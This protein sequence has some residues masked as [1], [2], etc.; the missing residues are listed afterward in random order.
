MQDD[1]SQGQKLHHE[2]IEV[3]K[4]YELRPKTVTKEEILAYGRA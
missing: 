1:L 4:P 3:G 2:D